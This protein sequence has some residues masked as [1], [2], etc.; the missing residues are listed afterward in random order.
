[1]AL[2]AATAKQC[3]SAKQRR[4]KHIIKEV[5]NPFKGETTQQGCSEGKMQNLGF[6]GGLTQ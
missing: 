1:V 2:A 6:E 4:L 5:S 3:G